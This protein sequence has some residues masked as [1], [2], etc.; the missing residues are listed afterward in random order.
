MILRGRCFFLS[1][2]I[3]GPRTEVRFRPASECLVGTQ[4]LH[5]LYPFRDRGLRVETVET[6]E[7]GLEVFLFNQR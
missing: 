1:E 5:R 7:G 3:E 6:I 4:D 2:G